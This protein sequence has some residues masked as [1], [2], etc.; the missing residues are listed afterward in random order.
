MNIEELRAQAVKLAQAVRDL[1][2]ASRQESYPERKE[3]IA[4]ARGVLTEWER[5]SRDSTARRGR[6]T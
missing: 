5:T 4:H 6:I 1:L 3:R 2:P